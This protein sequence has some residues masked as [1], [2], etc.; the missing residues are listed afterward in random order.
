MFRVLS[1]L[2]IPKA[3]KLEWHRTLLN[4]R[5]STD[6]KQAT[7]E[8]DKEKVNSLQ[9]DLRLEMELHDEDEDDYYTKILLRQ[10]RQLRVPIPYR[11][12]DSGEESEFWYQ[13]HYT[14][15]WYLTNIGISRLRQ[16]IRNEINARHETKS[17]WILWISALTGVIGAIT[18]L[19]AVMSKVI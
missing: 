15:G 16:E 1:K 18:G 11:R 4:R 8:K 10:A 12:G 7:K 9:R 19:V 6:I 2:P 5:Y 13:G 3:R 17:K 14:G